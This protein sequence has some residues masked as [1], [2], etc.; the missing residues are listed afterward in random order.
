MVFV[1]IE[2]PNK[3]LIFDMLQINL[4]DE[5]E[6]HMK[7]AQSTRRFFPSG[8]YVGFLLLCYNGYMLRDTEGMDL[9]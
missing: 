1:F 2:D 6:N 4:V 5:H 8:I 3:I 7:E 9:P